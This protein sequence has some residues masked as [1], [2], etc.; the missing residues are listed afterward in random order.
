[1]VAR[2]ASTK[3]KDVRVIA[4]STASSRADVVRFTRRYFGRAPVTV[5]WD[6][7][8]RSMRAFRARGYPEFRFVTPAGRLTQTR[9]PGFPLR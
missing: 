4:V 5:Y 7:S 8:G 6:P 3:R 1:V 2:Y 9:P